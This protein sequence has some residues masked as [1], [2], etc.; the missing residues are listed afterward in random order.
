MGFS[1]KGKEIITS[2][3]DEELTPSNTPEPTEEETE[4]TPPPAA[5]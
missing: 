3:G 4:E 5:E 1:I 2:G